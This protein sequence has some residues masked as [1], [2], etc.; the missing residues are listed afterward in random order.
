MCRFIMELYS[1]LTGR[2]TLP[3]NAISDKLDFTK[4]YTVEESPEF[5][6]DS[7]LFLP[8]QL[9]MSIFRTVSS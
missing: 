4:V 2:E 5:Y 7:R 1:L 6:G 8:L 3:S 9:K